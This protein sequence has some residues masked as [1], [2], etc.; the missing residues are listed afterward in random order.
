VASV[1]AIHE[2][3]HFLVGKLLGVKIESF[4]VGFGPKLLSYRSNS[5]SLTP[6]FIPSKPTFPVTNLDDTPVQT[7]TEICLRAI[8]LGGFVSFPE[9]IE[10]DDDGQIVK[11]FTDPDLLQNRPPLQRS[12][13]ISA[14]VLAN[15]LLT[16]LL[17][18][19]A[20]WTYGTS[21]QV[22]GDGIVISAVSEKE[23]PAFAAGL[24]ASDIIVKLNNE[25]IQGSELAVED[26]VSAIRSSEGK[27][28]MLQVVRP[29]VN[30]AGEVSTQE[31]TV[32]VVPAANSRGKV[33]IG[34]GINAV[35]TDMV[36]SRASSLPEVCA[37]LRL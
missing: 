32:A 8:P 29:Q 19:G 6:S 37:L 10:R 16:F 18:T 31:L 27:E 20:S 13:V 28:V 2:A 12:F 33:S 23:S 3:G 36:V 21:T 7:D 4:N 14:G 35:V 5:S 24:R 15:V 26:F 17:S 1:I 34:V 22:Y 11:Q 30:A 9:N 25:K